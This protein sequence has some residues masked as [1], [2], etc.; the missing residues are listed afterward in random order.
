MDFELTE[1]QLAMKELAKDFAEKEILPTQEKD[2]KGHVFRPELVKKMG[3]LGMFGGIIPEEYGGTATGFLSTLVMNEEIARHS[4]SYGLPFNMQV[5]GPALI[6]LAFGTDEQKK[7][8]VPA[9]ASA[10]MFGCFA[11]TEPNSGSDVVSM[12]TTAV[13][14]GD[15]FAVNGQKTWISNAHVADACILYCHTDPQLKHKGMSAFIVELK[16]T[17]GVTTRPIETKLGLHCAPTGEI[18]FED[19]MIPKSAMLGKR[20]DGFKICM[21]MLDNTRLSCASRAV[22][23]AQAAEDASVKYAQEREQFGQKIAEFQM[24]QEQIA[25]MHV[26]CQAARLL[27]QRAAS[28]KDKNVKCTLEVSVAK[29]YAAETAVKA[30]S[31]AVK[32]FGSYG[33]S[34][35]YP[36]ERLYRDSKSFQIVEGTSNIQKLIIASNIFGKKK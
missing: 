29:Y 12:K 8:Y 18:V 3:A 22:G 23:V 19:A 26:E 32:I 10:D 21:T 25:M 1:E 34:S 33:F 2:E 4:A 15:F 9:L 36:V 14:K 35:E 6:I 7:K 11:I 27:V 13:E 16:K 5:F 24:I 28:L 17:K 30:S 20:G 31:E